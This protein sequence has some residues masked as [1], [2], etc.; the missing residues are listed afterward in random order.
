MLAKFT[1][2]AV[3]FKVGRAITGMCLLLALCAGLNAA[4][5]RAGTYEV[6]ICHDP[7][8]GANAP[9]DGVSFPRSGAYALAGDSGG[10]DSTGY[11]YADLDGAAPHGPADYASW[12][13]QAPTNTTIVA[14]QVYSSLSAGP[15]APYEAPI[16]VIDAVSANGSADVLADCSQAFGCS[17]TGTGPL[18]EFASANLLDFKGLTDVTAIVGTSSCGGGLSCAAG[19]GASCPELGG[20]PC[21]VS[22]HL[23]AM[24]VTLEDDSAPTAANV[25]GSLIAPGAISGTAGL[26]FDATDTGAG[27]YSA[28]LQVDGVTVASSPIGSD[29]GRCEPIDDPAGVGTLRFDWAVPC[30]LSGSGSLELDTSTLHDGSHRVVATVTDAAGNSSTVWSGTI[31]TDNAP[32]G[33]VPQILGDPRQ[34]Q[35]LVA[36]AGSWSPAASGFSYQWERC[37]AAGSG[38][39]AIPGA[40]ASSYTLGAA[41]D[42]DEL[43]VSVTASDADGSTS[44]RS[45]PSAVVLDADGYASPPS[46]PSLAYG[47]L[48]S[49]SGTARVGDTLN[50]QPGDWSPG[51]LS[52]LYQWQRCDAYGLGCVAIDGA[53]ATSYRLT[54]ADDGARVR[55]L[56]SAS[57][58]GGGGQAASELSAV[59]VSAERST[60]TVAGGSA[61]APPAADS[62]P[63]VANGSGACADA[64]LH[65]SIDGG[66]SASIAYGRPA[67]LR[68]TLVCEGK[69]VTD[70][71]LALELAPAAGSTPVRRARVRTGA[72]GKFDYAVPP[73]P[74]R[75]LTAVYREYLT[76]STP[77]VS[78]SV[79]LRVTPTISLQITPTSTFNGDT[80]T[81]RGAVSGGDEPR[82][83]LALELEY[84]EGNRWMVYT[85][86]SARPGDG[87][88]LYR[89]TF[90]RTTEPITYT[91]RLAI[92]SGGVAG[93]PFQPTASPARSVHVDP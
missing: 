30:L 62:T 20:D 25:S 4:T 59:I 84:L 12:E 9:T 40:T 11:L 72:N 13:F 36:A 69:P 52:Y 39:A 50:A 88:F 3:V 89:Y 63:P 31:E 68:G 86:V 15:F 48:P 1:D 85:L 49:I 79:E 46:A 27:L 65:L 67:D 32:Q 5:A 6:A 35:T 74:S 42:Y 92:P 38:C 61:A 10:C 64:R 53:V 55:V 51:P 45:A 24:V 17:A 73:G 29:G 33:G 37:D 19:G 57:G 76:E 90:R 47:S 14:T 28:A 16:A 58:P 18:S 60:A 82:G 93:Y 26:S 7:A 44:V 77:S 91:F 22:N 21:I 41:D 54:S 2:G 23:Y 81:F 80:I 87:R 78:A 43:A 66:R 70:A 8:S 56:V 83:G 71:S 34:G 75:R